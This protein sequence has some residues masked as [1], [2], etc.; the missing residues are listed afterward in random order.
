MPLMNGLMITVLG[1]LHKPGVVD[2]Y[3][4]QS[5]KLS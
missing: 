4:M 3:P 2:R 5:V 1:Y